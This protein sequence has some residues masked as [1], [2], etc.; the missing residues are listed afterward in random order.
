MK[1]L[2]YS[3]IRFS[4]PEQAKGQ[5]LERQ[6]EAARD[7]CQRHN[8]HL[9]ES[10]TFRDLGTSGFTGEHRKN[11]DRNALALFLKMVEKGKVPKGSYLLIEN[12]DR[13]SREDEVPACHLLTG[14]LLAGVR[15][16]QLAPFEMTL[17]DKSNGW[18]LMRAVMELSR[19]HG[20]SLRKSTTM[21]PVWRRKKEQAR[22]RIITAQL[23]AWVQLQDGKLVLHPERAAIVRR[24]FQ[25]AACGYGLPSIVRRL[26][27]EGVPGF[28]RSGR[29]SRHYVYTILTDR[30]ALGEY[31]PKKGTR[32]SDRKDDGDPVS[33]YFPAVVDEDAFL[34]AQVG[35]AQRRKHPGRIGRF[36]NPFAGLLRDARDGGAYY[37]QNSQSGAGSK[38][39]RVLINL[40]GF[41]G[42]T[43]KVT[44][45]YRVFEDAAL[46][47]LDEIDP[48]EILNGDHEPDVTIR[49]GNQFE[50]IEAE[51][52]KLNASMDRNGYS[53]SLDR[54]IRKL[55]EQKRALS[56][57]LREARQR[58]AHP[59]SESWGEVKGVITHLDEADDP[60]D[61]RL[62]LRTVLR[63]IIDSI[64]LYVVPRGRERLA[65]VQIW[66][67]GGQT[68]RMLLINYLSPRG[69]G[70]KLLP[71]G[72]RAESWREYE[73]YGVPPGHIKDH[74]DEWEEILRQ[75]PGADKGRH[76]LEPLP[77]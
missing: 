10:T 20:E 34:A 27:T 75:L 47:W 29:W 38:L 36:V 64:W 76:G 53:E 56:E 15:V 57:E 9:D 3:Y 44:F 73:S 33:G 60:T 22:E 43:R 74:L 48:H 65:L 7:W 37:A 59:V 11:P 66:F 25:L 18:E 54:R 12:L 8:A 55:E 40:N 41:E 1:S 70:H 2:A 39:R 16:V 68:Y 17:T 62:R 26:T 50:G 69:N 77:D 19:G 45:P 61:A 4:S 71:G 67:A 31:Q 58:A 23:P 6:T 24:I 35:L 21:G 52:S 63:R 42:R 51:L 28:G 46:A 13:L 5:S 49:L 72:W 32:S 14:I 30:R